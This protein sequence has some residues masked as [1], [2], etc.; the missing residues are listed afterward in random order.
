MTAE[1]KLLGTGAPVEDIISMCS[2]LRRDGGLEEY[3]Q[4][5][6][7]RHTCKCGKPGSCP[8]CPH[9]SR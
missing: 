9:K 6:A 8:D 3:V 2:S 5:E 4:Q 7:G 1:R